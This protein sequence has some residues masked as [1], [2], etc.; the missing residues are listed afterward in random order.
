MLK[1]FELFFIEGPKVAMTTY[2]VM[3]MS[4]HLG[5]KPWE[6]YHM[7]G[8]NLKNEITR[9]KLSFIRRDM[10]TFI[11]DQGLASER[12]YFGGGNTAGLGDLD[13]VSYYDGT[14]F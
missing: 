1:D 13:K 7:L 11:M 5:G 14:G 3:N 4:L 2:N 6:T 8:K 10:G 12:L 9:V